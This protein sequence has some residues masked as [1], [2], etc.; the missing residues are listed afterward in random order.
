MSSTPSIFVTKSNGTRVPFSLEKLQ[1]SLKRA[2][3]APDLVEKISDEL[4]EQ[5]YPDMP[6]RTIYKMA[7]SMLKH[8]SRSVAGRYRLK[9]AIFEL[10]PSGFPFEQY[11]AELFR[12]AGYL[13]T[14]NNQIGGHCIMHEVDIRAVKNNR[15]YIIECKYHQLQGTHC[16]VKIPLYVQSRFEDIA[17][18]MKDSQHS[19]QQEYQGWLITNTRITSDATQYGVC[20]GLNMLSWDYPAGKGLKDIIDKTR[21]YP[22]TC[23]STLSRQEKYRL[24]E[25]RVILCRT[26]IEQ[27]VLLKNEHI[28]NSRY[29]LVLAEAQHLCENISTLEWA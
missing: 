15:V 2:G 12:Q 14:T 21:L 28:L 24:L 19:S 11:I 4:Y 22:I 7:Y 1:Q 10:G 8:A 25:K 13:T 9:Q 29:D 20:M 23:L 27:P 6:T 17:W 5:I 16:D 18:K 26:L 3:A